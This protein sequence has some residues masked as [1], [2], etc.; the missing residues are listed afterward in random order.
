MKKL[1]IIAIIGWMSVVAA[2]VNAQVVAFHGGYSFDVN[3]GAHPG[4]TD[5]AIDYMEN[6]GVFGLGTKIPS[7][8]NKSFEINV[9]G[10]LGWY[11]D[12]FMLSPQLEIAYNTAGSVTLSEDASESEYKFTSG[13]SI[14]G[15]LIANYKIIGPLGVW[16]KLRWLSPVGFDP[17]SF[18]PG[19]TTTFAIGLTMYWF[20]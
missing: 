18:G 10:G 8:H 12:N 14:G 19:G 16:T 5:F 15:G 9:H 1:F 11:W 4:R 2:N 20:R 3:Q 7:S 17:V 6:H 13:V